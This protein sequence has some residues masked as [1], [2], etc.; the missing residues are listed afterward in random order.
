MKIYVAAPY[1]LRDTAIGVMRDLEQMGFTV[2]SEW[3]RTDEEISPKMAAQDLRDIDA[4]DLVVVL[5]PPE[6]EYKGTG[7]RHFE[8]GYAV[9]KGK[10]VI[11]V[12]RRTNNFHHL[13]CIERVEDITAA[14]L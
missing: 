7:G 1:E 5:H 12:G 2:T 13:P 11:L 6:F 10:R 9:A 14:L 3:L 8:M 4:A